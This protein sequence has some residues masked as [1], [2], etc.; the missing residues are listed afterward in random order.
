LVESE[1]EGKVEGGGK[2]EGEGKLTSSIG[3]S[4]CNEWATVKVVE[5]EMVEKFV[6]VGVGVTVEVEVEGKKLEIDGEVGLEMGFDISVG[7]V[8]ELGGQAGD[9]TAVEAA[10]FG[11][12]VGMVGDVG[13][14]VR[15]LERLGEREEGDAAE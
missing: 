5:V 7:L 1:G 13:L 12:E 3:W 14:E 10:R 6:G 9:A 8:V 11:G 15:G 2:G 4:S